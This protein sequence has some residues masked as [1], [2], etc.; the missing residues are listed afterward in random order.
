[1]A[2][3]IAEVAVATGEG[4]AGGGAAA[5]EETAE[6]AAAAGK[7]GEQ[8][9]TAGRME[10]V[11]IAVRSGES[12]DGGGEGGEVEVSY[13]KVDSSKVTWRE[14]MMLREERSRHR[15]PLWCGG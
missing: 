4:R 2:E 14:I 11:A 3:K 12:G 5:A 10:R 9:A 8:A 13:G 6:V 7:I 15:Y 1:M